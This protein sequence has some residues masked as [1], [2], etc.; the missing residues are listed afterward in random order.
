MNAL[1]NLH[2]LW[3]YFRFADS[4]IY[5]V[6]GEKVQ[7]TAYSSMASYIQSYYIKRDD[8]GIYLLPF[9]WHYHQL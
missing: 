9:Y 2:F 7:E 6:D 4:E 5:Y 1:E 8:I 3:G